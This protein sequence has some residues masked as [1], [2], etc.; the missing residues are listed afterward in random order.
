MEKARDKAAKRAHR[1]LH[2]GETPAVDETAPGAESTD[3]TVAAAEP[4]T[5][6]AG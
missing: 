6:T 4:P 5:N 3:G 1:K 2:K